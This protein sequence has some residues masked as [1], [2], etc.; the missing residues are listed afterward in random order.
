MLESGT[1][2]DIGD[3]TVEVL[4]TPET[5]GD[6]Y[7][8]RI[9][10]QP[11]GPGI[12][13]DFPHIH[14]VLVETF[15]CVSGDMVA[16]VGRTISEVKPGEKVEVAPGQV[17]GFLNT[18]TTNLVVDGEVIFPDGYRPEDDLMRFAAIYDRLRREGPVNPKSGEP[19]L[20]QMAVLAAAN[21]RLIRQPG[22]AG[23]V[24]PLLAVLGKWRGYHSEAVED[25]GER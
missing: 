21:P 12:K 24:I 20:L 4:D 23:R 5:T 13:G 2:L 6:R 25:E 22:V 16:R 1:I 11:G 10:A 3:H 14:S 7:Q 9:V 19:P 18:G 17:H 15:Q 8:L